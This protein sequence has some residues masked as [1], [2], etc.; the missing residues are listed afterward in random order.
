M[1]VTRHHLHIHSCPLPL[2]LSQTRI[3]I[4]SHPQPFKQT[5]MRRQLNLHILLSPRTPHL[6]L[7]ILNILII[8]IIKPTKPYHLNLIPLQRREYNS[9]QQNRLYEQPEWDRN[10]SKSVQYR[11]SN[12]AGKEGY[13]GDDDIHMCLST[14]I[15]P[16]YQNINTFSCK[17]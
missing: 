16:T 12:A 7:K 9:Q 6:P 1:P 3:P 17:R 14:F 13:T 5:R 11:P 2:F 4:L 10:I 8:H 15:K